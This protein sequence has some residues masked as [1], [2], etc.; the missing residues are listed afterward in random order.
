MFCQHGILFDDP[1]LPQPLW[2]P[3]PSRG[4]HEAK[5]VPSSQK[6]ETLQ[7]ERL[8]FVKEFCHQECYKPTRSFL[9]QRLSES[10]RLDYS[11]HDCP[12]PMPNLFPMPS[13]DG[14]LVSV[15]SEVH[16]SRFNRISSVATL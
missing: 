1:T 4:G 3:L 13:I 9:G 14:A 6:R 7:G 16:Y 10:V 5:H 15:T 12:F 11:V 8:K 2:N